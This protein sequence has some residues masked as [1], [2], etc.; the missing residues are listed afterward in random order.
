MALMNSSRSFY[1]TYLVSD[2]RKE[3]PLPRSQLQARALDTYIFLVLPPDVA[4]HRVEAVLQAANDGVDGLVAAVDQALQLA[5]FGQ[6]VEVV[7]RLLALA[8]L[9]D[10]EDDARR[11][12][13]L[14]EP[15]LVFDNAVAEACL[16]LS[17]W[18]RRWGKLGVSKPPCRRN[19]N[20]G[21]GVLHCRPL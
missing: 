6:R 16:L 14:A 19:R 13:G 7:L 15:I 5:V 8:D 2:L 3:Y 11:E 21:K 10:D 12:P 4:L 1:I 20:K 18:L 17:G 9:E